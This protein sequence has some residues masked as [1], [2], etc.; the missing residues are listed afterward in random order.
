M[1]KQWVFSAQAAPKA[2]YET[3]TMAT[4]ATREKEKSSR[5]HL[6]VVCA[7]LLADTL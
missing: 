4:R 6:V 7:G 2:G 3:L 1:I 5:T